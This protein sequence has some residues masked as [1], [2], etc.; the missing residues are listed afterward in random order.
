[1]TVHAINKDEAQLLRN[2]IEMLM[3]ERAQLL[4]VVGAAAVFVANLDTSKLP[5]DMATIDAAAIE[6]LIVPTPRRNKVE[7]RLVAESLKFR[8][9]TSCWSDWML[10]PPR[11]SNCAAETT[12]TAAGTSCRFCSRFCAVTMI[13]PESKAASAVASSC[14][15][16]GMANASAQ[17]PV[18]AV[19]RNARKQ[20]VAAV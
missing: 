4:Q 3:G 16:A 2:E 12:L 5:D 14:A 19:M 11:C 18:S 10:T 1:M 8:L 17:T 15:A 13:S 20:D 6:K 9:G 7:S